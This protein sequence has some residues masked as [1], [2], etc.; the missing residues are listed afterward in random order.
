MGGRPPSPRV[1]AATV[2]R[3]DA[4]SAWRRFAVDEP[5]EGWVR[6]ADRLGDPGGLDAW[7]R[8]E[9][10]AT[11]RGHAD[12]AGALIVYRLAGALAELVVGPLLDQQR[13]L[14]LAPEAI[15]LRFGDAARLDA[16]SV[17]APAVAVL[18]GDPDAGSPGARAVGALADLRAVAV[19][20]LVAVFGP[21][22]RA[23]RARAPFGLRGMWGTLADHLAEVAVRRAREQRRDVEAAWTSASALI[24][25]LAARE[26]LLRARPRRQEVRW[27]GGTDLLVAK[28]TCC[29]IYKAAAGPGVPAD[30]ATDG[31]RVA[32]GCHALAGSPG[33]ALGT[34]ALRRAIDEAACTSCPLRPEDDRSTRYAAYLAQLR[35][36]RR[37]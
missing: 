32:D 16:L 31:S 6:L 1:V 8:T 35:G 19:E 3:L 21:L 25:D 27:P 14:E 5:G 12:L 10:A 11:A 20:G 24:A 26:T 13:C 2:G 30:G 7:Y 33:G 9:L 17:S 37:A 36:A 28:G 18:P 15:S 22:A 23:V 29:L 4:S 34:A